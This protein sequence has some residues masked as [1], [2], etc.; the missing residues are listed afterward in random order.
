MLVYYDFKDDFNSND[1]E[2]LPIDKAYEEDLTFVT[3]VLSKKLEDNHYL[4]KYKEDNVLHTNYTVFDGRYF[5]IRF[6]YPEEEKVR[7]EGITEHVINSFKPEV[8]D[9]DAT[10][11]EGNASAGGSADM[12]PAFIEGFLNDC[13]WE[14]L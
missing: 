9:L 13:Y 8:W 12:F 1:G 7:M 10:S 11:Q 6:E 4:I 3:G 5:T 2:P 14:K